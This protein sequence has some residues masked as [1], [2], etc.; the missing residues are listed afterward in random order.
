MERIS[1]AFSQLR[2]GEQDLGRGVLP[3]RQERLR[4]V[5]IRN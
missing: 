5:T 3:L 1:I 2:W 4:G